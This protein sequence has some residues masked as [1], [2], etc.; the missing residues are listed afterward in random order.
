MEK[1]RWKVHICLVGIVVAAVVIG[2]FYYYSSA[3]QPKE[4]IGG[5][6]VELECEENDGC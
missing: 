4:E 2:V 1:G 6:L 3:K 5:V